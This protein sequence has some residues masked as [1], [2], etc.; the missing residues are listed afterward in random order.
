M[1]RWLTGEGDDKPVFASLVK[2]QHIETITLEEALKLFE[3]PRTLGE[4]EGKTVVV[5][6]GR[7]GSY[8]RHDG[9]FTS[10]KKGVDDPLEISIERAIELIEEKREKDNNRI[11][12]TFEE[13]PELKFSME[14]GLILA[15]T[16]LTQDPQGRQRLR[17]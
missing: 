5:G 13:E 11:I 3:L 10:L 9:K 12:R 15:L 2:G 14:D 4:Y 1:V 8:I 6:V 17:N 7:F 16:M